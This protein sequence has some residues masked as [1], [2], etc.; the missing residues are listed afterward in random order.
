MILVKQGQHL[1]R[2][3]KNKCVVTKY[4]ILMIT[5]LFSVRTIPTLLKYKSCL[6]CDACCKTSQKHS[7]EMVKRTLHPFKVFG[8]KYKVSISESISEILHGTLI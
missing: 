4:T 2:P 8:S 3:I 6:I 5:K 1:Y 7:T